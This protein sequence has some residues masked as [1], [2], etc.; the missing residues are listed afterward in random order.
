MS[1]FAKLK[2]IMK[3]V[4]GSKFNERET[5]SHKKLCDKFLNTY[6]I[7]VEDLKEIKPLL[8]NIS[9]KEATKVIRKKSE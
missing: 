8:E 3:Y 5:L 2:N 4:F 1:F 6:K 7:E 9:E